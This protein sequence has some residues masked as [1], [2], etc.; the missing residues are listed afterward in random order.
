LLCLLILILRS[1]MF[2]LLLL[3]IIMCFLLLLLLFVLFSRS[4]PPCGV[5]F[6]LVL[7]ISCSLLFL[8]C[9]SARLFLWIVLLAVW[10]YRSIRFVFALRSFSL[11]SSLF[12]LF[13]VCVRAG[14]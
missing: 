5:W 14:V 11:C 9:S 3:I 1:I 2:L 8:V 12:V 7:F 10:P 6:L 13:C 4:F